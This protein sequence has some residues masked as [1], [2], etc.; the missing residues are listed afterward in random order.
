MLLHRLTYAM[1]LDT[2]CGHYPLLRAI[3]TKLQQIMSCKSIIAVNAHTRLLARTHINTDTNRHTSK[4]TQVLVS[5]INT[6]VVVC[7]KM[8]LLDLFHSYS[9]F[10]EL[11]KMSYTKFPA[12][13]HMYI[14]A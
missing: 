10:C 9:D 4:H 6:N 14:N 8:L 1:L 12:T 13:V 5:H 7:H 2:R 3:Q 11:P